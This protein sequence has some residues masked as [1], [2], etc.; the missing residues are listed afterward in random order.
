MVA[1]N[2]PTISFTADQF[3]ACKG[4]AVSSC[5]LTLG[6]RQH[7]TDAHRAWCLP[8][9]YLCVFRLFVLALCIKRVPELAEVT[10]PVRRFCVCVWYISGV[11]VCL[12]L[13]FY[14]RFCCCNYIVCLSLQFQIWVFGEVWCQIWL[15][16]DVWMCTASILNLCAISLDRYV[17]VTR[18]VTY[19]SIMSTKR[20]KMLVAIVWVLSFVICF[21][22]LVGFNKTSSSGLSAS[23]AAAFG[24]DGVNSIADFPENATTYDGAITMDEVGIVYSR[25][26]F[27]SAY[28]MMQKCV[29]NYHKRTSAHTTP[30]SDACQTDLLLRTHKKLHISIVHMYVSW[31]Q[32]SFT[33]LDNTHPS[34][35][36]YRSGLLSVLQY[37][38][39]MRP[40]MVYS[41]PAW[42]DWQLI[43]P[44]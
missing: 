8:S 30:Q 20:A 11:W 15:A 9:L 21:P 39:A 26:V 25:G 33:F 40:N 13:A 31:K 12:C 7:Y 18:P 41:D 38:A 6:V 36:L 16:L 14:M 29:K 44:S 24:E 5:D 37:T 34:P 17:A 4:T 22:P 2:I 35:C 32:A 1:K 19:P 3:G 27:C 10:P 28:R 42:V 43:L 23:R